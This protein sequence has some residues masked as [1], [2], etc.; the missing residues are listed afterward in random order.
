MAIGI[1]YNGL[2]KDGNS[3]WDGVQNFKF[4]KFVFGGFFQVIH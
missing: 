1:S 2:D 3:K 4:R